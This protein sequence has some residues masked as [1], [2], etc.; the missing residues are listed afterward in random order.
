[1]RKRH[2]LVLSVLCAAVLAWPL[3]AA[4]PTA[5]PEE[6][7]L[8]SERLRRVTELMQRHIDSRTFALES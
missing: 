7:G 2:S 6:V 5:K 1:M 8:S 3:T 4:A